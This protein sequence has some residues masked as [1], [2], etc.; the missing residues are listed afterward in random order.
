M[1]LCKLPSNRYLQD[2]VYANEIAP[3]TITPKRGAP[4]TVAQDEELSKFNEQKLRGLK[5]AFGGTG[6]VKDF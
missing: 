6:Y 2:N 1:S 5:P 4:T 3:I